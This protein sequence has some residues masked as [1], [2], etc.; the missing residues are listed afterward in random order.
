MPDN[1]SNLRREPAQSL[2]FQKEAFL[3]SF[4]S[5]RCG[6]KMR[7]IILMKGRETFFFLF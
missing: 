2:Y 7:A 4:G 6:E 3:I 1:K 5:D